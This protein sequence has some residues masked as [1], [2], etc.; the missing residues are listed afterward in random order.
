MSFINMK[1][2]FILSSLFLFCIITF[3]QPYGNEWIDHNKTYIKFKVSKDGIV[4][5]P[6]A[7]L[8]A[9]LT[10]AGTSTTTVQ[11]SHF[12]LMN[13]GKEVPIFTTTNGV[14]GV[15]DFIE[16]YGEKNDG[17]VENA[18][19]KDSLYQAHPYH[20]LFSDTA[21][22]FLT[23]DNGA[24]H[25]R[26]NA[27]NDNLAAPLPPQEQFFWHTER[28]LPESLLNVGKRK[29]L[30]GTL[31]NTP[32]FE[33][34][35]G[36]VGEEFNV[37]NPRTYQ[38]FSFFPYS[39]VPLNAQVHI[40]MVG[41]S[42]D[43]STGGADHNVDITVNGTQ[44]VPQQTYKQYDLKRV[45]FV[46]PTSSLATAND[47]KFVSSYGTNDRNAVS[48]IEL[49]YPRTY[50]L[51]GET[52]FKFKLADNGVD[53]RF[54]RF[55]NFNSNGTQ[56]IVYDFTNN[57]RYVINSLPLQVDVVLDAIGN[58][59]R[60][61]YISNQ[62]SNNI[63]ELTNY[64][65]RNFTNYSANSNQGD[66]IILSNNK[67]YNNGSGSNPVN[68]YAQYRSSTFGGNYNAIAVDV[69]ELYD[70]FGMGVALCPL[71][72][73]NFMDYALDNFTVTPEYLLLLG[74][75]IGYNYTKNDATTANKCLV[76]TWGETGS[77]HML[78][79]NTLSTDYRT[80]I[81]VGRVS[82]ENADQV[83]SYLKKVTDYE[84]LQRQPSTVENNLWQKRVIH[85]TGADG[86]LQGRF[87]SYFNEYKNLIVDSFFGA[88]IT[89]FSKN[90][91][92]PIT[93]PNSVLLD[94]LMNNGIS[95][96]TFWGHANGTGWDFD[97]G[98]PNDY[99]NQN[100]RYPFILSNSC[101]VGNIH[102]PTHSSMSEQWVLAKDEG[103]IG[104][105][106]TTS[107]GFVFYIHPLAKELYAHVSRDYYGEPWGVAIQ[108]AIGDLY[109]PLSNVQI[110]RRL[111]CQ[112]FTLEGDPA[113]R[114]GALN[115]PDY[116]VEDNNLSITPNILTA[117]VSDFDLNYEFFN[118]GKATSESF[119]IEIKRE[120]PDGTIEIL[121]D[122]VSSYVPYQLNDIIKNIPTNHST[123]L[124]LNKIYITVDALSEVAESNEMNNQ[125]KI[126]FFIFDDDILPVGPCNFGMVNDNCG[127]T[128]K[129]STADPTFKAG[130][131]LFQIDTVNTFNSPIVQSTQINSNGGM[132]EW[133]P[134]L[135]TGLN[136]F[137]DQVYY[138]RVSVD[139]IGGVTPKWH[140]SSFFYSTT[141][142]SGWHQ[143]HYQQYEQNQFSSAFLDDASHLIQFEK[144]IR[145]I[146][147]TNINYDYAAPAI[148][149]AI[150]NY[151]AYYLDNVKLGSGGSLVSCTG[152]G[153]GGLMLAVFDTIKINP[154]QSVLT[155]GNGCSGRGQWGNYHIVPRNL[156]RFEFRTSST[157]TDI[158]RVLNFLDNAIADGSYVLVYSMNNH[159]LD[160]A[161]GTASYLNDIYDRFDQLG[162]TQIRSIQQ[163]QH[164]IGFGRKN[165]AS[166]TPSY[167]QSSTPLDSL[168]L[169]V[170]ATGIWY[171]GT[172]KSVKVG[173]A[174]KW[175]TLKWDH[176]ALETITEDTVHLEIFGIDVAGNRTSIMNVDNAT[177][178]VSLAGI[179]ANTYPKLEMV[180]YLEDR[181]IHTSPQ[182]D[183]WE[184][185]FEGFPDFVINPGGHYVFEADTLAFGETGSLEVEITNATCSSSDS[186]LVKYTI[187][188][189][190]NN[191]VVLPYD[192]QAPL[193][194]GESFISKISFNT[195]QLVGANLLQVEVNPNEDQPEKY[196]YNNA[197]YIPFVVLDDNVNPWL[198]VTFDGIHIL[199]GD[200]VSAQPEIDIT[201]K[202]ENQFL[203]LTDTSV[204]EM[205]IIDPNGVEQMIN[206]TDPS[207]V[208]FT[209]ADPNN[210]T[211]DNTA[212]VKLTPSLTIDGIYELV[213]KGNDVRGNETGVNEYKITFEV[214]NKPM[215]SNLMNYPNPFTSST[216]FV[217]TLTGIDV[218]ENF[219]V[220][221]LTVSGKVV[222]EIQL[223]G[224][225]DLHIGRNVTEYRWD[226]TTEN[227]EQLGN[228]V[229]LYRVVAK[230]NGTDLTHYQIDETDPY[231]K[232]GFGKMYLMR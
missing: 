143:S 179:D 96:L 141:A 122:S 185:E 160:F 114:I 132:V 18:I 93:I 157:A 79:S 200:L 196:K 47:F 1:S 115:E 88:H 68:L 156:D 176:Y 202:D 203:A 204:L 225:E 172:M 101:F 37:S 184:V 60:E 195:T 207:L 64:S 57:L 124:G 33:K 118:I 56:P 217:F 145:G 154:L 7:T 35:E 95:L 182:I 32:D 14:F 188:D 9:A 161:T 192:R 165:R 108:K 120:Y 90:T 3:A 146:R 175:N 193:N 137:N 177:P 198:D 54:I 66:Y 4:R 116:H 16:F 98:I 81:A 5:I 170:G 55:L 78:V 62:T 230:L 119:R 10:D 214:I 111:T 69:E 94:S 201:L 149:Y 53:R 127:L 167:I 210:V 2:L 25:L 168:E 91:S 50:Q 15:N 199:D 151:M 152:V 19:Y 187:V 30:S 42:A 41:R 131:Y 109:D 155:S 213:V 150:W 65:I 194:A 212:K 26:I 99:P 128:L 173:P 6:Q 76:P 206:Y 20:S 74:K 221:V 21:I 136:L 102:T 80:R 139:T 112:E 125:A 158:P 223:G 104:F 134:G 183:Y 107:L 59:E 232:S 140:T 216:Q 228:G 105:M 208:T 67:L 106:A 48:F 180:A 231:F 153:D 186:L 169:D 23:W 11:G 209:P 83:T 29:N 117:N 84:A 24:G 123:A 8:A 121:Y 229:Y 205:S 36:Y 22:Y 13:K 138:W 46:V 43:L 34:G 39:S 171:K 178:T 27:A 164:F 63:N 126:E 162:L 12:I 45:N 82:A 100:G 61:M 17:E 174:K 181:D 197:L 52:K 49:T 144:H 28:L 77:D 70:Q 189:A 40:G 159:N 224:M 89:R 129:A 87:D 73:R 190:Q 130:S 44:Y 215:V 226:G 103:A 222:K 92:A 85:I 142:T 211:N 31:V 71:A 86:A 219:K 220:Q 110:G 113:I 51:I 148:S 75:S 163:D 133:N 38:V 191:L 72:L 97:I 58:Q 166:F 135:T 147:S 227:G 218:P